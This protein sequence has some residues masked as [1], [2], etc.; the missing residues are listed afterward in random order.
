MNATIKSLDNF[1]DKFE[2]KD[3]YHEKSRK[4]KE[5]EFKFRD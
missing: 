1:K 4:F 3:Y 5:K 2:Y